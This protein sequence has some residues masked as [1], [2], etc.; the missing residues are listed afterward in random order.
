MGL[1]LGQTREKAVSLI[2]DVKAFVVAN[3]LTRAQLADL[4][5]VS[6]S[7][8]DKFMGG[9]SPPSSK[10]TKKIAIKLGIEKRSL[11]PFPDFGI[12]APERSEVRHLEGTYQVIRPSFRE[13]GC[14]DAYSIAVTWDS[15][16][17]YLVFDESNNAMSTFDRG[18]VSV[19]IYNNLI[20][21]LSGA[22]GNF[23]FMLLS[24]PERKG[25]LYG[26]ILTTGSPK[27]SLRIPTAALVVLKKMAEDE[28]LV[29]G[30]IRPDHPRYRE[31]QDLLQ[32][33]RDGGFFTAH[34]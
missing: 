22:N 8:I 15:A 3:N 9:F 26:G 10:L 29:F 27:L 4:L 2:D 32:I 33:G 6:K 31:F 7:T 25:T 16:Q 13:P 12:H 20:Y 1:N 23:Q 5:S 34:I 14:L 19:P 21:F 18:L 28:T 30:T 24:D 17:A 11:S